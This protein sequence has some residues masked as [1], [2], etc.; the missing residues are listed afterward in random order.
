[1][2]G[3]GLDAA[4]RSQ[5]T[6]LSLSAA[7][8]LAFR[9]AV[10]RK[11][12]IA[13]LALLGLAG[14]SLVYADALVIAALVDNLTVQ[15]PLSN[16]V[17]LV[18]VLLGVFLL[19]RFFSLVETAFSFYL[20]TALELDMR[21]R[22]F[23]AALASAAQS[24]DSDRGAGRAAHVERAALGGLQE[25]VTDQL[26]LLLRNLAL[27]LVALALVVQ[28]SLALTAVFLGLAALWLFISCVF[29]PRLQRHLAHM[30]ST[31]GSSQN[32]FIDA[33]SAG[34]LLR[35]LG[36]EGRVASRYQRR[37]LREAAV[38]GRFQRFTIIQRG[39]SASPLVLLFFATYAYGG[40]LVLEQSLSVG[41][42]LAFSMIASR[43]MEPLNGVVDYLFSLARLK[44]NAARVAAFRP[45]DEFSDSAPGVPPTS[46]PG[47]AL[48]AGG[49]TIAR[50]ARVL[51]QGLDLRLGPGE[52][53]LIKGGSGIGK[54]TL[55]SVLVGE[56]RPS[57]GVLSLAEG[58]RRPALV[59]AAPRFIEGSLRDNLLLAVARPPTP[60]QLQAVL[61]EAQLDQVLADGD[62]EKIVEPDGTPWSHG[63]AQRLALARAL[64][65]APAVLILDEALSG[66]EP[67][68]ERAIVDGLR[69]TRPELAMVVMSH[70][71]SLDD[72][73]DRVMHLERYRPDAGALP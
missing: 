70:R 39:V 59:D 29:F 40:S 2:S 35:R 22:F 3:I 38:A 46:P 28:F 73:A 5:P 19:Q 63:Q 65:G 56:Q 62:L 6:P 32:L 7:Y 47:A 10:G 36:A 21:N 60:A 43:A 12:A 49:L 30:H 11:G 50:D 41:E 34:P 18:A 14:S 68:V 9:F 4:D 71:D 8:R 67:D 58:S 31:A 17:I 54:S 45:F 27:L 1:M 48:S 57:E 33:L 55:A 13:A 69:A 37:Q 24:R 61:A 52:L 72:R 44:V 53:L 25:H 20:Q 16:H 51:L 66:V 42:L 26:S 64:L 15:G 23:R